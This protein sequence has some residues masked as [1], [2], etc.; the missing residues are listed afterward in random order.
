MHM[1]QIPIRVKTVHL[2]TGAP[3]RH[4]VFIILLHLDGSV[5]M[6]PHALHHRHPTAPD[7]LRPKPVNM[8]SPMST[9]VRPSPSFDPFKSF[10]LPP[11]W[12]PTRACH[13]LSSWLDRHHFHHHL[14]LHVLLLWSRT[15]WTAH[16]S[17]WTPRSFDAKPLAWPSSPYGASHPSWSSPFTTCHR[18][19]HR[20]LYLHIT[21]Q[22]IHQIRSILSIIHH[23]RVTIIGPQDTWLWTITAKIPAKWLGSGKK[24]G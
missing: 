6:T 20:I 19:L 22:K 9:R 8:L 17:A 11:H 7:A 4:V 2:F 13:R 24:Q 16:D 10:A 18:L 3:D 14:A 21:S 1:T 5:A 23:P 12:Q 15:M